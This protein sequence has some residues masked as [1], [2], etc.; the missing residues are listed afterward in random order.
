MRDFEQWV[1][2]V[3]VDLPELEDLGMFRMQGREIDICL[4]RAK[5][6]E[7]VVLMEMIPRL[8]DR[9]IMHISVRE[10]TIIIFVVVFIIVIV[11]GILG[12]T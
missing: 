1:D 3:Q 2:V 6:E 10:G 12:L 7:V 9:T 5:E 8:F 11:L 4:A